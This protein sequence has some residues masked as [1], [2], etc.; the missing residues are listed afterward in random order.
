MSRFN[1]YFLNNFTGCKLLARCYD[2]HRE[3]DVSIFLMPGYVDVVGVSDGVDKWVAPVCASLFT[4]NIQN[5][6]Q[7]LH[8]GEQLNLP[9]VVHRE[10]AATS[11]K[12]P[13]R[14]IIEPIEPGPAQ[15]RRRVLVAPAAEVPKRKRIII[16]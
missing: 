14:V 12:R 13:R 2:P 6:L 16:K 9:L 15:P 4:V 5:L 8:A 1:S 3:R 11:Q 10:G 7:R